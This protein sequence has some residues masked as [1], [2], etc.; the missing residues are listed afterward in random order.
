[1]K[2]QFKIIAGVDI[3]KHTLDIALISESSE[4]LSYKIAN[5]H[6]EILDFVKEVKTKFKLRYSDLA[7]C[8]ENMGLY[9]KFLTDVLLKL[10]VTLF[11]ESALQ[12]KRSLGLQRGKTDKADA[13]RIAQYA[14]KN[15]PTLKAWE[16]PRPCINELKDLHAI[17]KRLLKI[18]VILKGNSKNEKFYLDST[19]ASTLA[20]YSSRS[21]DAVTRDI[22]DVEYKMVSIIHSDERLKH[23]FDLVTSVPGIGTIIGNQLIIHTNE[24]KDFTDA[25]KFASF[26]G[27]AP[28]PWSSGISVA[29]KNKISFYANREIKALLHIAAMRNVK[30]GGYS[31]AGYYQRK[32]KEGKNKMSVLNAIRNKLIHRVFSCV[33]NNIAIKEPMTG[34][35]GLV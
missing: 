27:V 16:P 30:Y 29:G 12:I 15:L 31:L 25:R 34:L 1:M 13:V 6:S 18:K 3:S 14:R 19:A 22:M 7:F 35:S 24:F 26:C 9:G 33:N 32:V 28:F 5:D 8:A 20:E 11:L 2:T 4:I 23:L 17:R 21:L 10:R